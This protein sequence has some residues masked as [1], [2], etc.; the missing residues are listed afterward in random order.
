[1]IATIPAVYAHWSPERKEAFA[2][3]VIWLVYCGYCCAVASA[4][5][6]DFVSWAST[7]SETCWP[8]GAD[9]MA[10]AKAAA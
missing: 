6:N 8:F 7:L 10:D 4:L 1:M 5:E 2:A 3:A 9:A